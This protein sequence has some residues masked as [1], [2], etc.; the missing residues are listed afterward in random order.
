MDTAWSDAANAPAAAGEPTGVVD[1][2]V[3][4]ALRAMAARSA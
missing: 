2:L 3:A 4:D 1:S